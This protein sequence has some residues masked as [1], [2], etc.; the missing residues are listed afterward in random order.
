MCIIALFL[1]DLISADLCLIGLSLVLASENP[2]PFSDL[3]SFVRSMAYSKL[4]VF[5]ASNLDGIILFVFAGQ[6]FSWPSI[7]SVGINEGRDK[8]GHTPP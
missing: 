4:D 2:K 3:F 8:W 6:L 7:L 1:W 5:L